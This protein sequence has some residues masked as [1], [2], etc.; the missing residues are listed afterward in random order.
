MTASTEEV[1][2]S[3]LEASNIAEGTAVSTQETV[4][5]TSKQQ[6]L[7]TDVSATIESISSM[8]TELNNIVTKFKL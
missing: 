5:L 3:A 6:E 8:S 1:S 4:Q 2:A 7:M